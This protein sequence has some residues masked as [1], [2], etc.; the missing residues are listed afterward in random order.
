[1]KN[2][3]LLALIGA[4]LAGG[5]SGYTVRVFTAS[6]STVAYLQAQEAKS[7]KV[8][9]ETNEQLKKFGNRTFQD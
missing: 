6:D 2:T 7:K 5:I 1:M 3:V 8:K 4:F 9:E